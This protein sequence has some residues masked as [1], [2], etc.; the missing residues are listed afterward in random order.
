MFFLIYRNNVD[1]KIAFAPIQ[2]ITNRI[3]HQVG[4]FCDYSSE[5]A[6]HA[7]KDVLESGWYCLLW[8]QK[9]F[10]IYIMKPKWNKIALAVLLARNTFINDILISPRF[11]VLHRKDF[12]SHQTIEITNK[13]I[14]P[15]EFTVY[16]DFEHNSNIT[17]KVIGS[18]NLLSGESFL[19]EIHLHRALSNVRY[20]IYI[21]SEHPNVT[22]EIPIFGE[23]TK[24]LLAL[25]IK[26]TN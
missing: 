6:L 13:C 9:R 22:L 3:W 16:T 11:L 15:R 2:K 8:F 5:K 20:N 23:I 25:L 21:Q 18:C 26:A 19:F 14:I 12:G 4:S 7:E 1:E 17:L 24:N 10:V